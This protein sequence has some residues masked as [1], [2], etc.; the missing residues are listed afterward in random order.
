[1]IVNGK[2]YYELLGVERRA[3]AEEIKL[4]YREIARIF[5]PDSN[6]YSDIT[7]LGLSE[8]DLRTFKEISAAYTTLIDPKKRAEYDRSLPPEF[9]SWDAGDEPDWETPEQ[10]LRWHEKQEAARQSTFG[11]IIE[12]EE[13]PEAEEAVAKE[14]PRRPPPVEVRPAERERTVYLATAVLAFV[15]SLLAAVFVLI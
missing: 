13:E 4:A 12:R 6:F 15:T 1:M 14:P 3:S 8:Q 11:V 2:T 10:Y 9:R 5:H 7:D